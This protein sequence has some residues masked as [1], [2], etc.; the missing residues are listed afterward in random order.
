MK[1]K[2]AIFGVVVGAMAILPFTASA[3]R[4]GGGAIGG[5][6][7][8]PAASGPI[9]AAPL[10]ARPVGGAVRAVG[11]PHSGGASGGM[12]R[13]TVVRTGAV[14]STHVAG[15]TGTISRV[16]VSNGVI[17]ITRRNPRPVRSV[18]IPNDDFFD[19]TNAVPGLGFDFVHFA[20]THPNAFKHHRTNLGGFIPFFSGGFAFPSI[21]AIVEDEAPAT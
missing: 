13:G 4:A 8:R 19:D 16:R 21:P 1:R 3:Q 12:T 6:M 2:L 10:A 17:H 11:V 20:A 15:R 7:A 18:T 5:G 9:A 14:G